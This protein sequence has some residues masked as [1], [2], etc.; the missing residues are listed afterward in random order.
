M[1]DSIVRGIYENGGVPDARYIG[2]CHMEVL[3]QQQVL[4]GHG[5]VLNSELGKPFLTALL[6]R[7]GMA[8]DKYRDTGSVVYAGAVGEYGREKAT[9][10]LEFMKNVP[11]K[12]ET[13]ITQYTTVNGSRIASSLLLQKRSYS[14]RWRASR[15]GESLGT[16]LT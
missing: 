15:T 6:E 3:R 1:M 2:P 10:M 8:L 9:V 14:K 16:Y 11:F 5:H 7:S 13:T 12:L 4:G